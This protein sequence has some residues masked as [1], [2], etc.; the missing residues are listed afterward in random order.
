MVC[1]LVSIFI[2]RLRKSDALM[3]HLDYGDRLDEDHAD[4]AYDGVSRLVD[5]YAERV[6]QAQR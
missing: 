2:N 4:R 6:L 5:A 1:D 3:P